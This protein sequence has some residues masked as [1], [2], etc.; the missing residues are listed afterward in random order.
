M[1]FEILEFV[2]NLFTDLILELICRGMVEIWRSIV[3][4][5]RGLSQGVET[6]PAFQR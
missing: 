6:P 1:I 5:F 4:M 3:E 2:F